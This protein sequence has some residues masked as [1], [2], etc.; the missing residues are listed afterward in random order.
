MF[1]DVKTLPV[2]DTSVDKKLTLRLVSLTQNKELARSTIDLS[3]TLYLKPKARLI[4][5]A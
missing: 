3:T 4:L 2:N 1:A 5:N